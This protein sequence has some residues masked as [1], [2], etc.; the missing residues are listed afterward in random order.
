[1]ISPITREYDISAHV[2][3]SDATAVRA[4]RHVYMS[5]NAALAASSEG[6]SGQLAKHL[7]RMRQSL[8][9]A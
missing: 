6:A 3:S 1:M 8:A 4:A 2:R 5:P 7:P 9:G